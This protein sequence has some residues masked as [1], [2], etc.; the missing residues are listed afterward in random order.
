MAEELNAQVRITAAVEGL[1]AGMAEAQASFTSATN[2]MKAAAESTMSATSGFVSN[3][4]GMFQGLITAYAL[5][6]VVALADA[7]TNASSR[8]KLVTTDTG[9]LTAVQERLFSISQ[10]TR[11]SVESTSSLYVKLAQSTKTLGKSQEETL[12]VTD[13]I[14]KAIIVSGSASQSTNAAIIQLGQGLSSNTLRGDELNSVLEQTPR[15]AQMIAEGMGITVG[16]LR[17]YGQ[18]GK[19]TSEQVFNA[20][21]SQAGNINAEFAKMDMTV[22]QSVT[23]LK[24][25]FLRLVG[26]VNDASGST[27]GLSGAIAEL[28][29]F[30]DQNV[31]VITGLINVA[32]APLIAQV[33]N[34]WEII[35]ALWKIIVDL[36]K[37]IESAFMPILKDLSKDLGDTGKWTDYARTAL[38]Y[39][40]DLLDVGKYTVKVI[41]YAIAEM[42]QALVTLGKV[43]Y[44]VFT[45]NWGGV[46][47]AWNDGLNAMKTMVENHSKD[48]NATW[49]DIGKNSGKHTETIIN[50]YKKAY[51][52]IIKGFNSKYV[53]NVSTEGGEKKV[54]NSGDKTKDESGDFMREANKMF[55]DYLTSLG[56]FHDIT[57]Q[58]EKS[59]W[60]AR[61]QEAKAGGD[62]YEK[63]YDQLYVKVAELKRASD[64]EAIKQEIEGLKHQADID[65]E[66]LG[67]KAKIYGEIFSKIASVYDKDSQEYRKAYLDKMNADKAFQDYKIKIETQTIKQTQA[68]KLEDIQQEANLYEMYAQKGLITEEQKLD[69]LRGIETQK[70]QIKLDSLKK[71]AELNKDNVD[72]YREYLLQIELLQ[73]QHETKMKESSNQLAINSFAP[74]KTMGDNLANSLEDALLKMTQGTLKF[75]TF[76][77]GIIPAIGQEFTKMAVKMAADWVKEHII[78]EAMSKIFAVKEVATKA[79]TEGAKT[80]IQAGASAT[81]SAMSAGESI[82]EIL[83]SAW[84]AAANVYKSIAAIPFVG[85]FLA[86]AMAIGAVAAVIGFARNIASA[87]GGYDIPSGVNPMTQLHQE[88]MVLPASIANPLRE[89]LAGGGGI[90]GGTNITIHAV[91]AKGVKDLFMSHGSSLVDALKKQNRAFVR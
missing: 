3:L 71:E 16:E 83:N 77:K 18:E 19:I 59:F 13:A 69:V 78:M 2:S 10:N 85:P 76:V 66:N 80:T 6:E 45:L 30:I 60:E 36:G 35:K 84:T 37:T 31:Q 49:N 41:I 70:Y 89:N 38:K 62:K 32:L 20:I 7:W 27:G 24:N 21:Q 9:N 5:K 39:F 17:K 29:S 90:G 63:A 48:L 58:E 33:R 72:K 75:S 54:I 67:N 26:Y 91:D 61:L 87:S 42:A 25:S 74:F 65:K 40:F 12:V 50:N 43:A 15:V 81:R 22:E 28:S 55:Q 8:L 52:S 34:A 79:V 57:K 73:K 11:Q 82:K 44:N 53:G 56:S 68:L 23:M 86:P 51:D 1:K 47:S 88:E 4:T 64:R 14:N 46:K